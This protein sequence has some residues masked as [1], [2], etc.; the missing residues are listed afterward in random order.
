M[1][2]QKGFVGVIESI[3]GDQAHRTVEIEGWTIKTDIIRT[4]DGFSVEKTYHLSE[5]VRYELDSAGRLVRVWN[6]DNV[7]LDTVEHDADPFY[8]ERLAELLEEARK[9]A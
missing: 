1:V 7:S 8:L 5:S 2:E 4:K 6:F 9:H 3:L